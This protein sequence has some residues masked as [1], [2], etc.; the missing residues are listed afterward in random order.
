[1]S[2]IVVSSAIRCVS[3]SLG[4]SYPPP[5]VHP[6]QS[7]TTGSAL[8]SATYSALSNVFTEN[9]FTGKSDAVQETLNASIYCIDKSCALQRDWLTYMPNQAAGWVLGSIS[10]VT[11]IGIL[12]L[13]MASRHAMFLD[14]VLAMLELCISL[15]LRAAIGLGR[16][17]LTAMYQASMFFEYHAGISLCHVTAAM[18]AHLFVHFHP[19]ALTTK[20]YGVAASRVLSICLAV[21][22]IAGVVVMFDANAGFG[23]GL[24]LV[25]AM[26]FAVVAV[27]LAVLCAVVRVM[28]RSGA[29]YYKRH[30]L[31]AVVVVLLLAVWAAFTGSRTFVALDSPARSSEPMVLVLGHGA[32]LLCGLVLLGLKAPYYYNFDL[33]SRWHNRSSKV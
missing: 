28:S 8:P 31:M 13:A 18:A 29:G 14:A 9:E 4:A 12:V 21:L 5:I 10:L 32:L 30:L 25:Q 24:A 17:N 20:K 22:A 6:A 27:C 15:Y 19:L 2:D 1:M 33:A 16:G 23:A 7:S 26:A 3:Q 11:A